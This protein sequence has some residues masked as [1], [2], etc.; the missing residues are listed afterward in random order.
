MRDIEELDDTAQLMRVSWRKAHN[1][2][3]TFARTFVETK[4]KLDSGEYGPEWTM[5]R[6]MI[7]KAGMFE[8]QVIRQMAVFLRAVAADEREMIEQENK[9]IKE[10][11]RAAAEKEKQEKAAAKAIK[12]QEKKKLEEEN[13]L[14]KQAE[15]VEK[16][17]QREI[18]RVQ[19]EARRKRQEEEQKAALKAKKKAAAVK[20][21]KVI[22]LPK[23]GPSPEAHTLLAECAAI[24]KTSRIELGK[25]YVAL[26]KRV[27]SRMEGK[28]ANGRWWKWGA[29]SAAYIHGRGLRSIEMYMKAF[30]DSEDLSSHVSNTFSQEENVVHFRPN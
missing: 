15:E 5:Q 17:R 27:D 25:R 24:E 21:K 26:K 1:Y 13:R 4:A 19:H 20:E 14:K 3:A 12:D 8:D 16:E 11:K 18:L 30:R 29:W 22:T 7:R 23:D 2:Y 6:W 10:E 28:D 9:R